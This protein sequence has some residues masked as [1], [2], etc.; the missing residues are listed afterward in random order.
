MV[1]E[2][3]GLHEKALKGTLQLWVEHILMAIQII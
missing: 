2:T 3:N 1:E